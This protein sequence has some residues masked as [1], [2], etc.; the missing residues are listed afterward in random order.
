MGMARQYPGRCGFNADTDADDMDYFSPY[1]P[2]AYDE[3]NRY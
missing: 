1:M 2:G 3:T